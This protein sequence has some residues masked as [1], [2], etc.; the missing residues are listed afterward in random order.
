MMSDWIAFRIGLCGLAVL[1][2]TV[3]ACERNPARPPESP[4]PAAK[5]ESPPAR[6]SLPDMLGPAPLAPRLPPGVDDR[7]DPDAP[8][9][10]P[11]SYDVAGWVKDQ[12]V[13][14]ARPDEL[15]A[16]VAH[17]TVRAAIESYRLQSAAR[18]VYRY[19]PGTEGAPLRLDVL[20]FQ[21]VD[22]D[23]A[24]GLFSAMAPPLRNANADGSLTAEHEGSDGGIRL[25]GWQGHVC[26]HMTV[27]SDD[28]SDTLA[29]AARSL[30]ARILFSI[31][32]ADPPAL[33]RIL[34]R[35]NRLPGHEW[36]LRGSAA[37]RLLGT[38]TLPAI[39]PETLDTVLGLDGNAVLAVAAYETE[40]NEPP[41]Y[42]WIAEYADDSQANRAVERYRARLDAPQ[43]GIDQ[44]TLLGDRSGRYVIGTWTVEQESVQHIL[45][46]IAA[47]LP[48]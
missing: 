37:M 4:P 12:P 42:V 16:I 5:R 32:R 19:N 46:R 34:P 38:E 45:P 43:D 40:P 14:V 48:P 22:P 35:E 9:A 20:W 6:S 27:L 39:P 18:C 17:A 44:D 23:D 10:L 11:R 47:G 21:M 31:P 3:G 28:E 13:R 26:L 41:N 33:L 29:G 1:L 30:R 36:L 15:A 24:F 25:F 2:I 8:A 7:D